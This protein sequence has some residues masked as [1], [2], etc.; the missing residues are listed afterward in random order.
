MQQIVY[1]MRFTGMAGPAGEST[2]VLKATTSAPSCTVTSVVGPDGLSG[3][4]DPT[5]GGDAA[6][7]S[8]VTFTSEMAFLETG[9]IAFGAGNALY[10][11]TIGSGHIGPSPEEGLM[12][13]SVMWQVDRGEGQ[14]EGASG[15]ITS[16]FTVDAAGAVTDHHF[17]LIFVR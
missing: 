11:S 15:L 7:E 14:F 1:A 6:F 4:I 16:N 13:G 3:S 9:T 10:F 5:S 12:H 2:T 8:T 17:G